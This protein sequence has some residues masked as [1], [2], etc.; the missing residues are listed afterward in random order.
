MQLALLFCPL[1]ALGG[2]HSGGQINGDV[3]RALREHAWHR[4]TAI[5]IWLSLT[6][7]GG[8]VGSP[9]K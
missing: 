7:S 3:F 5:L 1:L 4:I 2:G 8:L 6:R 9:K